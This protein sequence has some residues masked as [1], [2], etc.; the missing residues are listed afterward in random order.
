ML[1][2][3]YALFGMC[4]RTKRIPCIVRSGS[5]R[6]AACAAWVVALLLC[7]PRAEAYRPFDG[8]DADT[9]ELGSFELEMGPVHWY[10]RAGQNYLIAPDTVLNLGIFP[11]TELVVDFQD[12]VALGAL[13][14]RP[15]LALLDTDILVKHVFREG[16]LQGKTGLSIAVE[17]G[18]LTPEING[19]NAFGASAD[20]ILSYRWDW[21]TLHFNEWPQYSRD[22]HLDVF[23]GVIIEGPHE[24]L[25]RPVSEF[26]YEQEFHEDRTVSGLVGVIWTPKDSFVLDL[27]FRAARIG[28]ENAAELRLG[29]TWA[30]PVWERT[31][32]A[33]ALTARRGRL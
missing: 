7:A 8:T 31:E 25:V 12:F 15:R 23:S 17:A 30:L 14:G 26:F 6:A 2:A 20:V 22:H 13:N 3:L 27:A 10:D 24:W 28:D 32:N 5:R 18:P 9:A 29:F 11:G 19:T 4:S 21:G 1:E 16:I 33:A